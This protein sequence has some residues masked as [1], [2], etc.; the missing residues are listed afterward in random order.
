[1]INRNDGTPLPDALGVHLDGRFGEG[2][3]DVVDGDRVVGVGGA[4]AS[5]GAPFPIS[6]ETSQGW[7]IADSAGLTRTTRPRRR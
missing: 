7:R 5:A 1:M 2:R 4:G 3:I 6:L